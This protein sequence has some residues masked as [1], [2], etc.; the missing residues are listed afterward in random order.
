MNKSNNYTLPVLFLIFLVIN[1]KS[2][3]AQIKGIGPIQMSMTYFKL[4]DTL[5]LDS[6][7]FIDPNVSY[8]SSQELYEPTKDYI[9]RYFYGPKLTTT[10]EAF[11]PSSF[12]LL[13]SEVDISGVMFLIKNAKLKFY[14][15][16]L[17]EIE[18]KNPSSDLIDAV[19]TKY[20]EGVLTTQMKSVQCSS[21][22]GNFT[23]TETIYTTRWPSSKGISCDYKLFASLDDKCEERLYS[24]FTIKAVS[25]TNKI[26]ECGAKQILIDENRYR[27]E[28][29]KLLDRF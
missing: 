10:S 23:K 4:I 14:R 25:K 26:A 12:T 5:G 1:L 29:L 6:S 20:G 22:F 8:V 16:T 2:V 24:Y 17:V 11:C 3:E 27:K 19:K 13:L 28:K 7:K 9:I 15:D 21:I 18:V